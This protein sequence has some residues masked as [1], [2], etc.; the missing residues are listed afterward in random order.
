LEATAENVSVLLRA[1]ADR[2]EDAVLETESVPVGVGG[3][4]VHV[5]EPDGS[6]VLVSVM[7][8]AWVRDREVEIVGDSVPLVTVGVAVR[9]SDGDRVFVCE[10]TGLCDSVTDLCCVT[11]NEAVNE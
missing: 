11:L 6:T 5:L 8:R 7:D 3:V 4:A 1:A 9:L 2:D 10:G